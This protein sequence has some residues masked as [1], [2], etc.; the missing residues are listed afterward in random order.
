MLKELQTW[1]FHWYG[2]NP[3]RD[4][5]RNLSQLW[6]CYTTSSFNTKSNNPTLRRTNVEGYICTSS[7]S[8]PA[9]FPIFDTV[10]QYIILST[11]PLTFFI[12]KGGIQENHVVDLKHNEW[13]KHQSGF[14]SKQI[15]WTKCELRVPNTSF[16]D[17]CP[18]P[19]PL[20]H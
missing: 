16:K 1:K 2:C 6:D 18:I 14:L 12:S 20:H 10:R 7:Q 8:V 13:I 9:R 11:C 19:T 15:L 3:S 5:L 4:R 17:S